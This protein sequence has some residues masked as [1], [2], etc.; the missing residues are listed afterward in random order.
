M[1][2]QKMWHCV[3]K[4][5]YHLILITKYRRKVINKQ[6]FK[7]LIEMFNQI[8]N[9]HW[10]SIIETNF[11]ADHIHFLVSAKPTTCFTSFINGYKARSSRLIKQEFPEIKNKLWKNAF[12][13]RAYFL[14]TT[15]SVSLDTVK[16]YILHQKQA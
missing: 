8:G 15:G 7:R 1:E 5:T 11:E 14:A 13:S 9:K 2:Y 10:I 4:C 6:I 16:Q 3:Y 12:W